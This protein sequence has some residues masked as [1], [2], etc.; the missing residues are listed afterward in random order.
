VCSKRLDRLTLACAEERFEACVPSKTAAPQTWPS[1][2]K[3]RPSPCCTT[4]TAQACVPISKAGSEHADG[5]ERALPF[6]SLVYKLRTGKRTSRAGTVESG[7]A[8]WHDHEKRGELL[9][10]NEILLLHN[11]V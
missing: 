6:F 5:S 1:F 10:F 2:R 11:V 4:C 8:L 9:C 3:C 7:G